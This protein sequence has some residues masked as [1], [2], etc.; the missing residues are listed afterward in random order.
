M[1][2]T[3]LRDTVHTLLCDL[4]HESDM[5]KM[6]P[7]SS[8]DQNKCYYYLERSLTNQLELPDHVYWTD[9]CR[10]LMELLNTDQPSVVL[11]CVYRVLNI[12]EKVTALSPAEQSLF[13]LFY[14]PL[15]DV[16]S[17]LDYEE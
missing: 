16:Q 12:I 6:L 3:M 7:G 5:T 15:Q 1:S 17:D 8:R 13:G 2:L 9:Q 11:T 14:K 10:Q 4:P